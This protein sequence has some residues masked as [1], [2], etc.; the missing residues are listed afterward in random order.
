[1]PANYLIEVVEDTVISM[2]PI[3]VGTHLNTHLS[4]S[5]SLWEKMYYVVIFL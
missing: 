2:M 3:K 4:Y 1:M 5:F